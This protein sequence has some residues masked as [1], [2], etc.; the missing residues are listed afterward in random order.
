MRKIP[1]LKLGLGYGF[2]LS[3]LNTWMMRK[4][5]VFHIPIPFRVCQET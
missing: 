1:E 3:N 4:K 2:T 5:I